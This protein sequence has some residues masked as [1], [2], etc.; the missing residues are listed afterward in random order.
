MVHPHGHLL[1]VG[2]SDLGP[3][4]G[5]QGLG[6]HQG[7]DVA[8]LVRETLEPVASQQLL[9]AVH[10]DLAAAL[11]VHLLGDHPARVVHV[12]VVEVGVEVDVLAEV[13]EA[14][15][16]GERVADALAA[17]DDGDVL[18]GQLDVVVVEQH[19]VDHALLHLHHVG[20][21]DDVAVDEEV[22]ADLVG[23]GQDDA[24]AVVAVHDGDGDGVDEHALVDAVAQPAA[25]AEEGVKVLGKVEH[26]DDGDGLLHLLAAGVHEHLPAG[27]HA[28]LVRVHEES[29]YIRFL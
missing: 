27:Q 23:G 22:G 2:Q 6:Q 16:V 17:V 15:L 5:L 28:H 1:A 14:V 26:L 12:Q 25:G 21:V 20:L 8:H 18:V 13:G 10:H 3:V 24:L 9:E 4:A 7:L 29:H 11:L 19:G